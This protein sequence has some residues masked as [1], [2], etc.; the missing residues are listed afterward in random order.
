MWP[1]PAAD[2]AE[3]AADTAAEATE[4]EAADARFTVVPAVGRAEECSVGEPR[5]LFL[6]ATTISPETSVVSRGGTGGVGGT[7]LS[8][9]V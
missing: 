3:T 6:S 2:G 5:F 9:R 8:T 7:P 4:A 1:P